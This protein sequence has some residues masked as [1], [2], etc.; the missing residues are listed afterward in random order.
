MK[1]SG[2]GFTLVET[3]VVMVI[4][5]VLAGTVAFNFVGADRERNLRTEVERLG[6]LIELARVESLQRNEEWGVSLSDDGYSFRVFEPESSA[7]K[8]VEDRPFQPRT[9]EAATLSVKVEA[10]DLPAEDDRKDVPSIVLL[11]SGE[12]TPFEITITPAWQSLPWILESD[13]L[14]RA[15]AQRGT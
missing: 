13:G 9:L 3:L 10:F 5:A 8:D 4:V 15:E 6:A 11:S 12:I 14:S 2:A 1:R 7:W